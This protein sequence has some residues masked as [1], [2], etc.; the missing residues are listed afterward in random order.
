MTDSKNLILAVVLSALVLLGW[1]W[2]ANRYFPTSNPPVAKVENGKTQPLPQPQAQPVPN[3]PAAMRGRSA[4]LGSTPRVRI[5]TPSLQGSLN[6]KGA[7]IDDLLL[8]RE[9][10]DDREEFAAGPA[11]VAARRTGI[12]RRLVRLGRPGRRRAEPRYRVAGRPAG[13]RARPAGDPDDAGRRR[14]ALR[15]PDRGRRWLSVHRQAARDQRV[16]Q[17]GRASAGRAGQPVD[18]IARPGQLDGAGRSDQRLQ[19]QG[20][21]R[22]QLE[23]PR[24]GGQQGIQQRLGL[25]RLHRQILAD[26]AR[27]AGKYGGRV[28]PLADR[29]L[30][31]R[32]RFGSRRFSPRDRRNRPRPACSPAPSRRRCSTA[33]RA[34]AY[35]CSATPSTGAGSTGS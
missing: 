15:N 8:V 23:G 6:L 9:R 20:R 7:Q 26:R 17:A 16:G 22:H 25:A 30:P 34:R 3:S 35:R 28:P 33:I 32:L 29:R 2:F 19:R 31:G 10:A 5:Q 18:Q 1:G 14:S 12:L 4:V 11:V 24:P 27:A 21:L 13:P